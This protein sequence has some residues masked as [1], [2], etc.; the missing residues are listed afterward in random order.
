MTERTRRET[1]LG[2]SLTALFAPRSGLR[3][4]AEINL[5]LNQANLDYLDYERA[6]LLFGVECF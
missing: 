1:L 3:P 2:G 5:S 4:F 6:E